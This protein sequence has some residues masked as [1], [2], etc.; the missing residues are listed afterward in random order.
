MGK[1]Q[2]WIRYTRYPFLK[3]RCKTFG[4]GL[5]VCKSDLVRVY[6]IK[7]KCGGTS[8]FRKLLL[9]YQVKDVVWEALRS[10]ER[11]KALPM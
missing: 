5:E 11:V 8:A 3:T 10:I 1:H 4:R 6:L 2:D 7:G 9:I